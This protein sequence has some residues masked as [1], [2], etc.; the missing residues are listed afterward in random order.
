MRC[1][2]FEQEINLYRRFIAIW[3][4]NLWHWMIPNLISSTR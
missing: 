3:G 2:M 4:L 1:V